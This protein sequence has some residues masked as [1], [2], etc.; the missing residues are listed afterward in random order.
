MME[1]LQGKVMLEYAESVDSGDGL[2][3]ARATILFAKNCFSKLPSGLKQKA[4]AM[5]QSF[6]GYRQ[7]STLGPLLSALEKVAEEAAPAFVDSAL[8]RVEELGGVLF[9]KEAWLDVRRAVRR[10]GEGSSD[11]LSA[12][13]RAT[14]DVVRLLGQREMRR[15]V[16]RVRLVKGQ[17]YDAC[18]VLGA[19]ALERRELYVAVTRPCRRLS[20]MSPSPVL[21]PTS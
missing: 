19:D 2:R 21:N 7:G 4:D 11:D 14:R 17:E 12:A 13:I 9:R 18:V 8:D 5:T 15:V 20:V 1:E 10:W 6:P 16:S 3:A